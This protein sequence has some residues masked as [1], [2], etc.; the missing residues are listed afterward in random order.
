MSRKTVK[1]SHRGSH[2]SLLRTFAPDGRA[3]VDAIVVP[4]IRKPARLRDAI[5]LGIK[6]ECPVIVLSSRWS[7]AREVNVEA[8]GRD[9]VAVDVK[10]V[11]L[12]NWP[13]FATTD[14]LDQPKHRRFATGSDLSL[15]RNLGLA[16][17][18]MVGWENLL[19]LDDDMGQLEPSDIE[20]AAAGLSD[21]DIVGLRN[22]GYPDN[23]VVCHALRE[24]GKYVGVIQHSFVGG[25]AMMVAAQRCDAF[26][27]D[28]YNE[29]WFFMLGHFVKRPGCYPLG[30]TGAVIQEPYDPFIHPDRARI[31]EFGDCLAEGLF[32]LLDQR[33]T[34]AS[35]TLEYW[36]DFLTDRR[37]LL[38]RMLEAIPAHSRQ[39][40]PMANCIR[41]AQGRNAFV[42]ADL[43]VQYLANWETDRIT[44]QRYIAGLPA[45]ND[46][47][48]ALEYLGLAR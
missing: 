29:D 6:L 11:E 34:I 28:I 2:L 12:R 20:A 26:F 7:V 23:S 30:V 41:A 13:K 38:A 32:A 25:G 8:S 18:R 44:W 48:K 10:P 45:P 47:G 37:E 46:L 5:D 33:E 1:P 31:E 16:I 27:P 22:V 19:F 9:V 21:Y 43:C 15:K 4:T 14:L 35:A 39:S 24:V 42:T 40:S 3:D 17:A 36:Q